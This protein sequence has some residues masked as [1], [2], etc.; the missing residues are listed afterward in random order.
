[1]SSPIPREKSGTTDAA[2]P[3]LA[4]RSVLGVLIASVMTLGHTDADAALVL[5]GGFDSQTDLDNW[6]RGGT[7]ELPEIAIGDQFG[8]G[9]QAGAGYLAFM[10]NA[11]GVDGFVEQTISVDPLAQY[12]LEFFWGGRGGNGARVTASITEASFGDLYQQEFGINQIGVWTSAQVRF[13]PTTNS[14]TLRFQETSSGSNSRDPAIDSV[15]MT[16]VASVPT[17]ST[18]ALLALGLIPFLLRIRAG[19]TS[20]RDTRNG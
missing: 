17:T 15:S 11:D 13:T 18:T 6:T 4:I 12:D 14:I 1:M 10:G 20:R 19:E 2:R 3:N 8:L 5:G 16:Q 7:A 9:P